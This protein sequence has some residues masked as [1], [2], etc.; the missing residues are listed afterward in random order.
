MAR[1]RYRDAADT[2]QRAVRLAERAS[3]EHSLDVAMALNHH[4]RCCQ[5]LARFAEAGMAYQRALD[6]LQRRRGREHADVASV[7]GNLAGLEH[8]AGNWTRGEPFAREA[9]RIRRRVLGWHH[10]LTAASLVALA[11]L[12]DPQ[13]KC[14]EAEALYLKALRIFEGWERE[15]GAP[16]PEFFVCLDHL[17]AHYRA[18][19]RPR[20]AEA[21]SGRHPVSRRRAVQVARRPARARRGADAV[22]DEG[23]AAT[24]TINPLSASFRL[25]VRPSPIH[26]FGV[27]AAEA[28]P[29]RRRVIEYT[30]EVIGRRE[31]ARRWDPARSY[32][33]WLDS[34]RSVDGA[35]GG[36]GAE[37]INHSCAPNLTARLVRGRLYYYSRQRSRGSI[38]R[39]RQAAR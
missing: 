7:Y 6:I 12:L 10:P 14:R 11:A 23:V 15:H 5:H 27:Y 34:Y 8:A 26:R 38:T 19:G 32:L 25:F 31:S 20:Q 4:G 24:A 17:A 28:I 37:Y 36:S 18:R 30:G 16:H 13:K 21:I 9:L 22:N 29:A 33:F 39:P 35:I 3:G 1:G 2:L